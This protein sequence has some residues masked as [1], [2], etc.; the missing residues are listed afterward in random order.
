MKPGGGG[1]ASIGGA[2]ACAAA[3]CAALSGCSSPYDVFHAGGPGARP[4]SQVIVFL[5]SLMCVVTLVMG[6]LIVLGGVRRRGTLE[7]HEAADASGGKLWILIGGLGVPVVVLVALFGLTV[8]TLRAIPAPDPSHPDLTVDVTAHD[9]WWEVA[10]GDSAEPGQVVTAN[11]LHIPLGR[12]V[13]V[14]LRSDDV[15]HSFWVPSLHGKLDA[16]P[17]QVNSLILEADQPGA[18]G[19][20]CAEY[21]GEQHAHMR[22]LV[23][24]EPPDTFAAWRAAQAAPARAPATPELAAGERAFLAAPCASCHTVRGT[25]AH[26]RVGPD[27]THV[28]GRATIAAGALRNRPGEMHA[29]I[30]DAPALKPGARMPPMDEFDGATLRAVAAYLES[31]R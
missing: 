16:I 25:S 18:Y 29:W 9:W 6:F 13:R 1:A 31:L 5:S 22:F 8:A 12:R 2:G 10:Y 4:V 17:G 19:G 15:I 30:V 20:Q 3:L 28:G 11:E 21:C 24:A 14:N 7:A 23:V 26:G 27:L